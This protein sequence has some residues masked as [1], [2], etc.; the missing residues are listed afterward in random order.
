M[1]D[2]IQE[3][4]RVKLIQ[5]IGPVSKNHKDAG[6]AEEWC[7]FDSRAKAKAPRLFKIYNIVSD[8]D[9]FFSIWWRRLVREPRWWFIN[10]FLNPKWFVRAQTLKMGQW[11][12]SV[13]RVLHI[14]MQ[15]V[16]DFIE[17]EN[18]HHNDEPDDYKPWEVKELEKKE[19]GE[20]NDIDQE[21]GIPEHQWKA[22]KDIWDVYL[23]W[24]NYEN[25]KQEIEDIYE[26]IPRPPKEKDEPL[27]ASFTKERMKLTKPYH[28]RIHDLEKKL[29]EEIEEN[30]IKIMK[31]RESMWS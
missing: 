18:H 29:S 12:D 17:R 1:L 15:M 14:N 8:I 4:L 19:R 5:K 6:T 9:I 10:M 23:W 3:K 21:H 30:L 28:D 22:K 7:D 27:M 11:A 13:E 25:R 2:G 31:N 16:V 20:P 24:K 26:E